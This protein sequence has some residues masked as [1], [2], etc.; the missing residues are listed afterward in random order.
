MEFSQYSDTI[1][2]INSEQQINEETEDVESAAIFSRKK[3]T[4]SVEQLNV[5]ENF[6]ELMKTC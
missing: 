3:R 5:Q 2:L 1:D 4:Y 6:N